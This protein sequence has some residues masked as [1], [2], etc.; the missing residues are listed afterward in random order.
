[1]IRAKVECDRGAGCGKTARPG[2]PQGEFGNGRS[3]C[4]MH[5]KEG[6][7]K[8]QVLKVAFSYNKGMPELAS[9]RR[10]FPA[11]PHSESGS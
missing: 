11:M 5:R 2:L 1:M 6:C 8:Y 4:E 9:V 7:T 10:K 3:Y